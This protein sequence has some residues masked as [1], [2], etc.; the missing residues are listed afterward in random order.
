[1]V[2]LQCPTLLV[3][4]IFVLVFTQLNQSVSTFIFSVTFIFI[5]L[6][7]LKQASRQLQKG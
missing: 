2:R 1:M 6:L 5:F 7:M 4:P 3:V